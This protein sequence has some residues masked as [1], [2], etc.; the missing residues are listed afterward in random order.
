M[1][2]L[3]GKMDVTSRT[4]VLY[5]LQ[6]WVEMKAPVGRCV[7]MKEDEEPQVAL[8]HDLHDAI[9]RGFTMLGFGGGGRIKAWK[10]MHRQF[11]RGAAEWAYDLLCE[12][13]GRLAQL[14]LF[15]EA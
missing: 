12:K 1:E 6:H 10:E 5:A 7:L 3:L 15:E 4:L 14:K 13:E 9:E 11:L 2:E 8:A